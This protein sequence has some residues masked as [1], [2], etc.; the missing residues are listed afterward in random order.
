MITKAIALTEPTFHENGS[1]NSDGTCKRWRR[2]GSTK[3]WKSKVN[4]ERFRV[5][6]KWGLYRYWEVTETNQDNFHTPDECTNPKN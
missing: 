1:F 2:N 3:T 6:L 5:P 4:A